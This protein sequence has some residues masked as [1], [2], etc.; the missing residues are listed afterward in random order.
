MSQI[1]AILEEIIFWRLNYTTYG[2]TIMNNNN[3]MNWSIIMNN[4][5]NKNGINNMNSNNMINSN[6][7]NMIN[8]INGNI[9]I[10]NMSMN[11]NILW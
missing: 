7:N 11:S 4:N 1:L 9:I 3:V 6:N 10:S 5:N 8:K 2:N